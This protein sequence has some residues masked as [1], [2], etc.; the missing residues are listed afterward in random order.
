MEKSIN[1]VAA[2]SWAE[3]LG[4]NNWEGLLDPLDLSLRRFLLH[5][6]DLVQ[7]VGD[8]YIR[9]NSPYVGNSRYGEKTFFRKVKFPSASAY[10]ISSFLYATSTLDIFPDSETNFIGYVATSTSTIPGRG[11]VIYVAWRGTE[12]TLEWLN[13]AHIVP[14]PASAITPDAPGNVMDGWIRI[15]TSSNPNSQFGKLS[16]REQLRAQI[17]QLR[18]QYK[19]ENLSIVVAGHSLGAA[20]AVLSAFDLVEN[21][22]PDIP[23]TAIVFACPRVG[24][25]AFVER[26][27]THP[28]LKIL[29]TKNLLDPVPNLPPVEFGYTDAGVELVVDGSKSPSLKPTDNNGDFHNLQGILHAVAGWHGAEGEFEV[30]VKRSLALVNKASNLL[31]KECQIPES[32]WVAENKGMM[33]DQ[34][35]EWVLK[36]PLDDN[37]D[38]CPAVPE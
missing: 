36:P 34:D 3:L 12:S 22:V 37:D 15:Y 32:W 20:L 21:V 1:D 4:S 13:N 17:L 19:D 25:G 23:V 33:L 7:C 10:Q 38:D 16:A 2:P 6:G 35:G 29:H 11:R 8:A 18:D 28:S 26:L 9:D 27:G 24:D 31:T 30:V 14:V 5:C